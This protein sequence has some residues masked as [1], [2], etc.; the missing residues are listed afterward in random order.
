[1]ITENPQ[2]KVLY[3]SWDRPALLVIKALKEMHREDIAIFTTD[4][5]YKI[6]QYME[7]GIVKGLSTQRPYEQGRTAAHVVAKSLLSNDVPKYVGVQP[8]VVDSKQL[9]RAW[10][11]IFHEGMP[12]EMK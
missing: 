2:I 5:D 9:G 10:K 7:S 11:D 1:M 3:V 4:L 8:Y 6:A 12:E